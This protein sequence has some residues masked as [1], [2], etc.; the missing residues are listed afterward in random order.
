[1]TR[2]RRIA[3]VTSIVAAVSLVLSGCFLASGRPE[4]RQSTP[5]GEKVA[6]ELQEYYEQELE[7]EA[8]ERVFDCADAEVPLDWDDPEGA[9]IEIALVRYPATGEPMGSLLVNP[10]GPGGSGTEQVITGIDYATSERLREHYDIVGFDPRG[11]GRSSAID[12]YDDPDELTEF[13]YEL[14]P[15]ERGSEAWLDDLEQSQAEFGQACLEH[16]G[17]LLGHVDTVSAAR[18]MDVL[19]AALGDP[20]L[21]YLGYSY[22]TLLGATY[23]D[24]YAEK[25]GHLVLDGAIDPQTTDF[26]VTAAQA[27]GFESA[28]RAYLADCLT[29]EECPFEGGT[30]DEGMAEFS[31]IFERLEASPL[32]AEDGR[33]LGADAMFTA[34]IL[35][36]YSPDTWS[37]LSQLVTDVK[38]GSAELAFSLADAYYSRND[39]GTFSDNSTEAFIAINCLDYE[40]TSTRE[41]LQAEAAQLAALAPVFG[42]LMS[43]G[44]TSCDGWPFEPT[45][46][47]QA[48]AAEGSAPILVIGTTNDPATPYHWSVA[49]A[50]QLEN[51]R[52]VTYDGEGHTAY[53][54][55]NRCVNDAVDDFFI[56]DVVPS[57]DPQC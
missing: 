55:S 49:L 35:P 50:E 18:D 43:Y 40:S 54:K 15:H 20:K 33:M 5:T 19:R 37:Y 2:R 34:V 9:S 42:P 57:A 4:P 48:I 6:A 25:T 41:T 23:A 31:R 36:L 1:M 24:L 39:D 21:N 30:V 16:S 17:E 29:T 56:D 22:G 26:D 7:W 45:R 27:Q 10:G 14:S 8:C 44:G 3:A 52:L 46:D 11:V 12:C 32:R 38:S 51:G 13:I 28:L 53:N 47:R